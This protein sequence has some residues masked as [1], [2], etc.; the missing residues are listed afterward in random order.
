[1]TTF[2]EFMAQQPLDETQIDTV[3]GKSK[4]SVELVKWYDPHLLDSI[5]T[6]ANLAS[7]VYGLFN[8]GDTERKLPPEVEQNL[9]YYGRVTRSN[10]Q[11]IPRQTLKQYYPQLKDDQIRDAYTIKVNVNRILRESRSDFEAVVQIAST[12][13]H[14]A[15]HKSDYA[16]A[17][18]AGEP[19]AYGAERRFMNWVQQN[20]RAILQ[21]Y[22]ELATN[23]VAGQT[24]VRDR[25]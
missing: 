14:E 15:T 25:H 23:D 6:I 8:S 9:L 10:L 18:Q 21:K 17:G 4:I 2:R 22:P 13:V 3:Y 11:N 7:G 19:N 12:I 5:H 1:M 24:Q 20:V 16:K